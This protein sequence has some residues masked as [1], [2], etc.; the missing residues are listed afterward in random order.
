MGA[1]L[2]KRSRRE[3]IQRP[4]KDAADDRGSSLSRGFSDRFSSEPSGVGGVKRLLLRSSSAANS[5][6]VQRQMRRGLALGEFSAGGERRTEPA[7]E[8]QDAAPPQQYAV[9]AD[10]RRSPSAPPFR[11]QAGEAVSKV[12]RCKGKDM[13]CVRFRLQ[14]VRLLSSARSVCSLTAYGSAGCVRV[15]RRPPCAACPL[16][17]TSGSVSPDNTAVWKL[18]GPVMATS[19]KIQPSDRQSEG[20]KAL[21]GG[22]LH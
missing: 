22:C 11:V 7:V 16:R 8:Q 18:M 6:A 14:A 5:E 19:G 12:R 10:P 3:R 9:P 15:I 1:S 13:H 21:G 2:T 17:L 20:L 4:V